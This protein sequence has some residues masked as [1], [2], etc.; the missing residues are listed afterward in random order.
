[1]KTMV[2]KF[3]ERKGPSQEVTQSSYHHER[4]FFAPKLED[5]IVEDTLTK[6]SDGPAKQQDL[7]ESLSQIRGNSGSK[8]DNVLLAI[9]C[10]A[11]CKQTW[12]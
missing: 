2:R 7:A 11:K 9:R 12:K 8:Q 4:S 1:M 10:L 6:K 3:L 5:R